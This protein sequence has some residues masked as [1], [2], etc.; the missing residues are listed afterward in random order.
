MAEIGF[1]PKTKE[2][3]LQQKL[4]NET[5]TSLPKPQRP[6]PPE[7]KQ[8]TQTEWKKKVESFL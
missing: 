1:D 7:K 6:K 8:V 4:L 5:A 2:E 3:I